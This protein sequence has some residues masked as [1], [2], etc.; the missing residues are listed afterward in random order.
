MVCFSDGISSVLSD[1]EVVGLARDAPD[2]RTA[3][4]QILAF[5]EEL[6]GGEDNATV[7]VVPLAGWGKIRGPDRT[8]ALREYRR[9][10]AGQHPS[11]KSHRPN[12]LM[13]THS[14][15][16]ATKTD[17]KCRGI[18]TAKPSVFALIGNWHAVFIDNPNVGR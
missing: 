16:R 7:V 5:A 14:R 9:R 3:A 11:S 1:D 17:V 12:S 18:C 6:S 4:E 8:K 2:P 15:E 10:Q 13:V